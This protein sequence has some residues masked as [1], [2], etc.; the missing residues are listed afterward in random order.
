MLF[1]G[2]GGI[3]AQLFDDLIII[4][5]KTFLFWSEE[6]CKYP[7]IYN[8]FTILQNDREISAYF[9]CT[10]RLF[11]PSIWNICDRRRLIQKFEALGGT[12]ASFISPTA[13]MSTYTTVK[14][15]CL[16]LN[17]VASEPGVIIGENCVIN[18]RANFG[19]GAFV[20]S[21]CSVG[22]YT[23]IASDAVIG[24]D[25][26]IGM[27]AIIQP[28]VILGK[29]V[30]VAAGSVVTKNISNNAVVAGVPATVRYYKEK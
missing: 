16:I 12:P 23:I 30:T 15:G 10:S 27:G 14:E 8:N 17:K 22:P 4:K 18:K 11:T 7:C 2:A 21:F 28:K 9:E 26:Y 5:N 24:E 29:N 6:E 25:S 13:E 20:D 19:H 1:L 3:A